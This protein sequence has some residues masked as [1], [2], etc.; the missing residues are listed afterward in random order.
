[1]RHFWRVM[2]HPYAVWP[3]RILAGYTLVVS[4]LLMIG[5]QL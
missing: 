3:A 1:M 2:E 4:W 5:S